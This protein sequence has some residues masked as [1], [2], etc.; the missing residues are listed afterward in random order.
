MLRKFVVF[1]IIKLIILL[2][3]CDS[4]SFSSKV[5]SITRLKMKDILYDM[6]VSNHGARV[7][8]I[9]AAK[10][11]NSFID[12][13]KPQ[14][15]GG[16]KSPEY[17]K[18]NMQGK[19]PLYV[20]DKGFPIPESDTICRY[21]IDKYNSDPSFIPKD[22]LLRSLSDQI[23]RI[24]DIYITPIQGCLYKAPGSLFSNYGSDRRSALN[25]LKKQLNGIEQLLESFNEKFPKL[26]G[27]FLCGNEISLS[28]ATLFPTVVF[29][30]FMF[31]QFFNIEVNE[32]LGPKLQ[33]WFKFLSTDVSYT[34]LV[35]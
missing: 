21:V 34:R 9:I 17:L 16:L 15:I 8:I 12:I 13:K 27:N 14:D 35:R 18:L 23:S 7:R 11:L 25:E 29:C 4:F 28:D 10:E 22:I 3:N 19:M 31:P 33:K 1:S 5:P 6:P 32:F 26:S 20:T 30:V 24:H 2:K